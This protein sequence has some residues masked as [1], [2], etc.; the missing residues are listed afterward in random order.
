[1]ILKSKRHDSSIDSVDFSKLLGIDPLTSELLISRGITDKDSATAF[2]Y[3]KLS[4]L[5]D[6]TLYSGVND[7]IERISQ[8][9]ENGETVVV[10][11]DYDCDGI[12]ASSILSQ[13][14]IQNGINAQVFIP[15]RLEEGYGLCFDTLEKLAEE[16]Y[17]DLIITVDCGITSRDEIE[18][19]Q[20][21]LGI[22]V[23]VTDHHEPPKELPDCV[24]IN[25]H[26]DTDKGLYSDYC[27]AGVAFMLVKALYGIEFACKYIDICA[28][29]TMGDI[30]P[31]TDANRVIVKYGIKKLSKSPN[32]GLKQLL[33]SLG[34][35]HDI[36]SQD[37][38]FKIVPRINS[39]GRLGDASRAITLFTENDYFILSCL[40]KE[41]NDENT[42]RQK[43][44]LKT[45]LD[46]EKQA[47]D[48]INEERAIVLCGE[49]HKGVLGI[50]ASKLVEKF[51]RPVILFTQNG[52]EISG[53][54]R[55]IPGVN[56]YE[57]L[58]IFK[59]YFT[60]FGGH[61]QAAGVSMKASNFNSFTKDFYAYLKT[62]PDSSFEKEDEYDLDLTS[63]EISEQFFEELKLFEPFGYKNPKPVFLTT[64]D[65]AHFS[66][67]K[68]SPNHLSES[69]K[70]GYTIS[71][72][73]KGEYLELLN[74]A[75]KKHLLLSLSKSIFNGK[76]YSQAI[77]DGV[78]VK[79]DGIIENYTS[80]IVSYAK[81]AVLGQ[82]LN[83]VVNEIDFYRILID[84]FK[85]KQY[86]NAVICFTFK[87]FKKV[88]KMFDEENVIYDKF[89]SSKTISNTT[90]CI[91]Y[92]PIKDYFEQYD[93]VFYADKP[94]GTPK[95]NDRY[96][97]S[98]S[99]ECKLYGD[100]L[101]LNID[102]SVVGEWFVKIKKL[103]STSIIR[104]CD[105]AER[106]LNVSNSDRIIFNLV[107]LILE[108]VEL[109]V[110]DKEK[111]Y[112]FIN[113]IRTDLTKSRLYCIINANG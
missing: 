35:K 67:S 71:A 13:A 48:I 63:K 77:L 12:C 107:W 20:N 24:V 50:A 14:L 75:T 2:L 54:C 41:M 49:W 85:Q 100:L 106:S 57:T 112:Y 4:D 6:F 93:N 45:E 56:I 11:G 47:R 26:L 88:C 39:L 9:K 76:E 25:P 5:P 83:K 102:R 72:F 1:M 17:P 51:N 86:G 84:S 90:N 109:L 22:D 69:T 23:I 21:E 73:N 104:S 74:S 61:S 110:F 81:T 44:C 30:V 78:F 46:A 37:I 82:N 111:L 55:S 42:E 59:D 18:Y 89:Y 64:T 38:S 94:L 99:D 33:D 19:C 91:I 32:T 36:T 113:N 28:V 103:L 97:I 62:M 80:E 65:E 43:L 98:T 53:S 15:N 52:D 16:Y 3:P 29:A 58:S 34:V 108:E 7:A 66:C 40:I 27:G 95:V 70:K 105:S 31:L 60:K 8:A 10:Y 92:C 96:T 87:S 79:D 101:D 68:S